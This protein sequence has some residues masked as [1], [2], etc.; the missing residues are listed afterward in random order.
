MR[1]D[2]GHKRGDLHEAIAG[3]R[4]GS[5][6]LNV[7]TQKTLVKTGIAQC[8]PQM[9][10]NEVEAWPAL[11]WQASIPPLKTMLTVDLMGEQELPQAWALA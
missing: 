8:E 11:A 5:E 1:E 6:D 3:G 7:R 9:Q 10:V 4:K 2:G